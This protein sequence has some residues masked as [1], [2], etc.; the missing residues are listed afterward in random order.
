MLFCC[1]RIEGGW[2]GSRSELVAHGST[3]RASGAVLQE[4]AII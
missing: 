2:N 4:G 3:N 1:T